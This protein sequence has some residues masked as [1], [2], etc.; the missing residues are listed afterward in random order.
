M[1]YTTWLHMLQHNYKES[2]D[3][4]SNLKRSERLSLRLKSKL[5]KTNFMSPVKTGL[6]TIW[7]HPLAI[8]KTLKMPRLQRIL[9]PKCHFSFVK[10]ANFVKKICHKSRSLP[11]LSKIN[12]FVTTASFRHFVSFSYKIFW[13]LQMPHQWHTTGNHTWHVIQW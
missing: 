3:Q 7:P 8:N 10:S 6:S 4:I 13:S 1:L 12:T 2:T 9:P 5:F 11:I